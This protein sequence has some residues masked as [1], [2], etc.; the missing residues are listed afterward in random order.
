MVSGLQ[1]KMAMAEERSGEEAADLIESRKQ[2]ERVK[3]G[4]GKGSEPFWVMLTVT[5]LF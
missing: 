5:C 3:G 1:D 4:A 2:R